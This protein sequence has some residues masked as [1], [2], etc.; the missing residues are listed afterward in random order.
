MRSLQIMENSPGQFLA[1]QT[2]Y[3]ASFLPV[4]GALVAA[5]FCAWF[6]YTRQWRLL[7]IPVLALLVLGGL[8]LIP[9]PPTFRLQVNRAA[10]QVTSEAQRGTAVVTSFSVAASDLSGADMQFNRGATT[11]VLIRKNGSLLYPLGEQHLQNEPDQYVVLN[12]LRDEISH[13]SSRQ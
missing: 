7:A 10:H 12:V 3:T 11:I 5:V 4:L 6:A 8:A 1:V 13:S 9:R 2:P